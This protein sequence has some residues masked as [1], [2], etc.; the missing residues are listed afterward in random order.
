MEVLEFTNVILKGGP[1]ALILV[2]GAVVILVLRHYITLVKQLLYDVTDFK[3]EFTDFRIKYATEKVDTDDVNRLQDYIEKSD[4]NA[5]K[6][7]VR[8][9][10]RL[11]M[12]MAKCAEAI[13][14]N[15][16]KVGKT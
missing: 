3:Q 15:S 4:I 12:H 10:D 7:L 14:R 2:I 6:A 13:S 5:N 11:N 8:L 16:T 1:E 9:E